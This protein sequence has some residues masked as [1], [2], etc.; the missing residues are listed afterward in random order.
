MQVRVEEFDLE[1]MK[2]S[3]GKSTVELPEE[4]KV[5][6]QS[7]SD[8][9]DFTIKY[10]STYGAGFPRRWDGCK[11]VSI[12]GYSKC[13]M[14]DGTVFDSANRHYGE[15]ESIRI[16]TFVRKIIEWAEKHAKPKLHL[17]DEVEF[18]DV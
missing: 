5:H 16:R 11:Y 8:H 1:S 14:P 3:L 17:S 10:I 13:T 18:M 9:W 2:N 12:G 7:Y 15:T 4:I 6:W